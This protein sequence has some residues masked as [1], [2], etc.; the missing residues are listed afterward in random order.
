[1]QGFPLRQ[2][3]LNLNILDCSKSWNKILYSEG[4]NSSVPERGKDR[5]ES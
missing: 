2:V 5:Q 4:D 3:G 1:M